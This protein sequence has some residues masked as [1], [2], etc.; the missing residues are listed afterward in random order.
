MERIDSK[1][2]WEGHV[3]SVRA[4]T[5]RHDDG[6]EAE[7]EVVGHPGAV[8]IVAHDEE[9]VW[10]V[11]QPREAA[12][13]LA[14]LEIPA[15]KLDEEGESRLDCAKRELEE[16]VGLRAVEWRERKRVFTSPG[17]SDEE[18]TVFFAIGLEEVEDHEGIE[19][20]RIEIVKWPLADLAGAIEA[21]TNAMSVL[22]LQMLLLDRTQAA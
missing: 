6:A 2:V 8:G 15:G 17:F 20:E 11:R 14:M 12:G 18:F 10:L 4:E 21:S 5:W 19:G 22:S 9:F 3:F 16:E 1:T 7:R 13:D